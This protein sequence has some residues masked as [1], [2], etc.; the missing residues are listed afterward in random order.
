MPAAIGAAILGAELAGTVVVGTL[1]AGTIV[2]SV[3][4]TGA[5][6]GAQYL[7][8]ANQKA[9]RA[10]AIQ[11]TLNQS[12][13]ARRRIYG[14]ALVGGI[15]NFWES[16]NGDLTQSILICADR[17]DGIE[18]YYV[19]DKR[20][21]TTAGENGGYVTD[22]PMINKVFFE[23]HLGY[24]SQSASSILLSRYPDA[25]TA[26][27]RLDGIAYV[28]SVFLAVGEE[29]RNTVYPQG[30]HTVLRFLVRG[31]LVYDLLGSN[32]PDDTGLWAWSDNASNCI[33]DYLRH[34]DGMRRPLA[35]IDLPSFRDFAGLCAETVSRKDGSTELRYRLW[36][37]Y[38]F[39]EEPV[40][41]LARMCAA[42]DGTLYQGPSGKIG[43]RGGKWVSP[44][45]NIPTDIIVKA[46]LTQG[47][48]K[49][50]AYN[51]LKVSYT[52]PEGFF[53]PTEMEALDD[54]ASQA[55][56]GVIDQTLDLQM[57]P[58]FSQAARIGKI[59]MAKDNPL[60]KGTLGTHLPALDAL[61][62]PTVSISYDPLPDGDEPFMDTAADL[63]G[64][65]LRGDGSGCDL[66]FVSIDAE[67]YAWDPASDEPPQPVVP[68]P[69]APQQ[70]IPAPEDLVAT[71]ERPSVSGDVAGVQIR[72]AWAASARVDVAP[73]AQY[74]VSG[75]N[76]WQAMTSAGDRLSA[77]TPLLSDGSSYDLRV[78]FAIGMVVSDWSTEGPIEAIADPVMTAPPSGFVANGSAGEVMLAWT[79]PNSVNLRSCRLYRAAAGAPFLAASP[80]VTINL[81][82]NQAF[83]MVDGGLAAADYDYW[84]RALNRGGLG[85]ASSTTGP[86]T[87]T[88]T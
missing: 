55:A 18:G 16:R 25:W 30:A 45:V 69:I 62:E 17:I 76:E 37:V 46:A 85:D 49:L 51:R 78:R 23:P 57:V 24:A 9:P 71:V 29:E 14:K 28:V 64:F 70:S 88:V 60:W 4:L 52:E 39:S 67:A 1:T 6:I 44:L 87:A 10:E 77:V 12:M 27:H 68:T 63:S 5:A 22:F 40:S 15:R 38:E 56:I 19:G 13:A 47:N 74:A 59:R 8:A 21:T 48:D 34:K 79:A 36:G 86:I 32:H 80:I 26:A 73:E 50:D 58:S 81:A 7:L 42:C 83:D 82:P 65:S 31:A 2:G 35:Q 75:T 54:L 41:A 84:V 53:Q 66:T 20:V 11:A 61:G 3:V 43:I 72:L 33:L